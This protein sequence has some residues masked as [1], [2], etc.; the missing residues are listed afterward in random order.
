MLGIS[1]RWNLAQALPRRSDEAE[2]IPTE[3]ATGDGNSRNNR[4]IILIIGCGFT[5]LF[6]DIERGRQE[7][8]LFKSARAFRRKRVNDVLPIQNLLEAGA[9][10]LQYTSMLFNIAS[11]TS[12]AVMVQKQVVLL[13]RRDANELDVRRVVVMTVHPFLIAQMPMI[14]APFE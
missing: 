1:P 6:E 10:D 9:N 4:L 13:T 7:G 5:R 3:S 8:T 14:I 2:S 11:A 12:L